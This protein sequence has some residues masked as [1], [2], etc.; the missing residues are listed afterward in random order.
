MF[1][2]KCQ[3]IFCCQ[4]NYHI[5]NYTH[6]DCIFNGFDQQALFNTLTPYIHCVKI[7]VIVNYEKFIGDKPGKELS[8]IFSSLL[9]PFFLRHV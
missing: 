5:L 4:Y 9:I 3:L 7:I 8:W 2:H 6:S 1:F